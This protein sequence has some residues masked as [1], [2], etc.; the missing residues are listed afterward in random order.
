MTRRWPIRPLSASGSSPAMPRVIA[1]AAVLA[2]LAT[3]V[4]EAAPAKPPPDFFGVVSQTR[5][6]GADDFDRMSRARV[7]T[8][9]VALP[10]Q[11]VDPTPAPGDY[12][13]GRFD[14]I[15]TGAARR[16]IAVLPTVY[17]V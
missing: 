9:R 16:G 14:A 8:V 3:T 6:L 5:S 10:W 1:A 11:E 13:W 4:A 2:I 7:G 12:E 17:T 15:V